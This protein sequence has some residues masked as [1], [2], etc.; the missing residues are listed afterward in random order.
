MVEEPLKKQWRILLTVPVLVIICLLT[1]GCGSPSYGSRILDKLAMLSRSRHKE[2][3]WAHV[4]YIVDGERI[5]VYSVPEE[6][7]ETV[8]DVIRKID[9]SQI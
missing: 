1:V 8:M 3:A 9:F 7:V 5:P 6:E 4:T 2:G